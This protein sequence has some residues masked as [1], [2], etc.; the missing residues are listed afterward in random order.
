MWGIRVGGRIAVLRVRRWIGGAL[1]LALAAVATIVS[2]APALAV[3]E[4]V[5]AQGPPLDVA[6]LISSRDDVCYDPGDV[7]AITRLATQEQER[8]NAHGGVHGRPIVLRFLDDARDDARAVANVRSALA[9][10]SLLGIVGLTGSARA[11]AV[12]DALGPQI[13][14]SAV[15]FLSSISVTSLFESYDNVYTTRASQDDDRVPMMVG[16][17]R[18]MGFARPAFVGIAGAVFSSALG[19]GLA[20]AHGNGGLVADLR[21]TAHADNKLS[22]SEIEAMVAALRQAA[23]DLV[24]LGTG[25]ANSEAVLK[26]MI[27]AGVTPALFLVG[28]ID[29]IPAQVAAAYPNAMYQLLWDRLPE[30]YNDRLRNKISLDDPL[31]WM[32]EGRKIDKAPGWAKGECKPRPEIVVPDPL[33]SA[34]LRA[35]GIGTQYADMVALLASAARTAGRGA[36]IAGYRSAVLRQLSTA[37]VAGR[38]AFKGPYENW[39]FVSASRAAARS[40]FVIIL[41]QGLGRTQLAPVQFMRTR[42]GGLRQT[43]TLYV[44]VDLVK[45]HHIDDNEESFIAE[46]YLSMRDN[47]GATIDRVEF[48]NA[49]LDP[50]TNGRQ[51][52]IEMLHGGGRSDAYPEGMRIYK[53]VGRFLFAP[54]LTDYPFDRQR[55]SIDIQPRSGAA[56]FIVQPPPLE[57]RDQEA[58]TDG[59]DVKAQYVGYEEDFVPLVDAY[60]HEPSV[61]PFY[62]ARFVWVMQRQTTDYYLRV[63]VPLAFILIVA[64]LSVFIPSTNFEAI[65]TIQVTALLSAVAL[66]LSLP[67]LDSDTATLSDR[68]FVFDYMMVSLMIVISILKVNHLVAKR[69]WLVATMDIIH[70]VAV[71]LM[72]AVVALY[73]YNM[74]IAGS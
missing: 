39:S 21:L 45:V 37:Y 27:Q 64:Y 43:E 65:V 74:G 9:D 5:A 50:R 56:P 26:A 67:K 55:F 2:A 69:R 59:W 15:P 6:V 62:K 66:Y 73:V 22:P 46:L 20:Q 38:G 58:I 71:P 68:L 60:T 51:L 7:A 63:V 4:A 42:D 16:F 72:V 40:P 14:G 11:K 3:E 49:Y 8:I 1:V 53:V 19:D 35:I 33:E 34:N 52:T 30:L 10:P 41:P 48:A 18:R 28:R 70:I 54:D 32:F 36:D 25:S 29:Q 23:P 31:P 57:L 17:G 61:V 47:P 13:G 24:Y 44:D 12:F